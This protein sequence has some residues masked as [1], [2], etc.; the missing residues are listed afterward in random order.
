MRPAS[1]ELASA[2]IAQAPEAP[3]ASEV[4]TWLAPGP[5]PSQSKYAIESETCHE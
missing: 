1:A 4:P 2:E 3:E 5:A